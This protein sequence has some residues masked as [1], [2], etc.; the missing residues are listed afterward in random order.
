[1]YVDIAGPRHRSYVAE[2]KQI[3]KSHVKLPPG[4]TL[5]WSGQYEN[6][7]RVRERMLVVVPITIF[8][9]FLLIYFNTTSVAKTLI[10]FLAVPF[11]A[12]GRRLAS[13]SARITT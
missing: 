3:V 5:V 11:S 8:I 13:L 6:M 7:L 12:V 2:A 9:I 1:M 10:I 4:Y